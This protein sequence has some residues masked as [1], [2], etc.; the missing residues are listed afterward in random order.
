VPSSDENV[1]RYANPTIDNMWNCFDSDSKSSTNYQDDVTDCYLNS[2]S[3]PYLS[4]VDSHMTSFESI[5]AD[6]TVTYKRRRQ[7][8]S[9]KSIPID[10]TDKGIKG[11]ATKNTDMKSV[12]KSGKSVTHDESVTK[13]TQKSSTIA[14]AKKSDF[15]LPVAEKIESLLFYIGDTQ[16]HDYN[17]DDFGTDIDVPDAIGK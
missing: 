4:F 5:I 13:S 14:V 7:L 11:T 17:S 10:T 3:D 12:T 9:E 6:M 16:A 15:T 2:E 8:L 1:A